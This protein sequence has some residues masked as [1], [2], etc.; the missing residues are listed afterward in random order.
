MAELK[1]ERAAL[2]ARLR[3]AQASAEEAVGKLQDLHAKVASFLYARPSLPPVPEFKTA[4]KN[5]PR[6]LRSL[7]R[8]FL[9]CDNLV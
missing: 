3:E 9:M 6:R 7:L 4:I 2:K 5:S 1:R 8:H